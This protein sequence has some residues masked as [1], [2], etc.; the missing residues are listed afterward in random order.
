MISVPLKYCMSKKKVKGK[1]N[2]HCIA[3]A[4][5]AKGALLSPREGWHGRTLV[6]CL[7][8]QRWEHGLSVIN[9]WLLLP[10][11]VLVTESCDLEET[12]LASL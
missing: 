8:A 2:F 4:P 3:M 7:S 11:R 12:A 10:M 1:K 9:A 6:C 5:K